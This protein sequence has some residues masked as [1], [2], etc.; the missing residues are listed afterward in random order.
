MKTRRPPKLG[1]D[2]GESSESFSSQTTFAASDGGAGAAGAQQRLALPWTSFS[3]FLSAT[4]EERRS[5]PALP[6][7]PVFLPSK[8]RYIHPPSPSNTKMPITIF[9][10]PPKLTKIHKQ[11]SC[12]ASR[13]KSLI[14]RPIN[15]Y[16][17]PTNSLN[18][19][20]RDQQSWSQL[21]FQL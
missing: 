21:G 14:F 3:T 17:R 5:Q 19:T 16:F 11:T 6:R 12:R 18:Q 13:P 8:V 20:T 4:A 1:A 9:N 2:S 15:S 7:D 10:K